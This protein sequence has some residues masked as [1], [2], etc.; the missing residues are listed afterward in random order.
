MIV[1]VVYNNNIPPSIDKIFISEENA[2]K[3]AEKYERLIEQYEIE[4][5]NKDSDYISFFRAAV[6]WN[7]I[8]ERYEFS[9]MYDHDLNDNDYLLFWKDGYGYCRIS[10]Y[11]RIVSNILDIDDFENKYKPILLEMR[12]TAEEAIAQGHYVLEIQKMLN[13]KYIRRNNSNGL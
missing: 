3:Y 13:D 8:H 11:I 6:E 12:S 9:F 10:Y 4:D 2:C 7:D 5:L 1:Y